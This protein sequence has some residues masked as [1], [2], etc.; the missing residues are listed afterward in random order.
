ME[1]AKM[2]RAILS[3]FASLLMIVTGGALS[4]WSQQ[5]QGSFTGTVT[6]QTGADVPDA[7]VTATE[8][9]TGFSRRAITGTDGSY[10]IP[11]L[12]PG[13]Y[14]ITA[15][16]AGFERFRQAVTLSVDQHPRIDIPLKIGS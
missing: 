10:T 6:D 5:A 7:T 4:L 16:K 8:Q 11:L 14:V 9:D 13:R 12:P 2:R 1:E 15:E 3:L